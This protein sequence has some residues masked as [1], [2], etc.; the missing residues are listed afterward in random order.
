M[1]SCRCACLCTYRT[2]Q[3]RDV[4]RCGC[5]LSKGDD[6]IEKPLQTPCTLKLAMHLSDRQTNRQVRIF[7]ELL[8]AEL[9]CKANGRKITGHLPTFYM[10]CL[11][12]GEKEFFSVSA[13]CPTVCLAAMFPNAQQPSKDAAEGVEDDI[14]T[15]V[16]VAQTAE[17]GIINTAVESA[18]YVHLLLTVQIS[19][20][21]GGVRCLSARSGKK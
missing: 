14:N 2:V 9:K 5:H 18:R 11:L 4:H 6:C 19:S 7:P 21:Q 15:A 1:F 12:G 16:E 20:D 3:K 17:E 8:A 10:A 13:L